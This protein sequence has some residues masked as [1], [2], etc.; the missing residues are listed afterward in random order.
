MSIDFTPNFA[1]HNKL[2]EFDFFSKQTLKLWYNSNVE[3]KGTDLIYTPAL[4]RLIAGSYTGLDRTGLAL[5]SETITNPYALIEYKTDFDLAL[6]HIGPGQW[7]GELHEFSYYRR[8]GKLQRLVISDIMGFEVD[9]RL[10]GYAYY[11][12]ANFL[13]GK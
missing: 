1:S 13:N 12:M 9:A 8:Y 11:L 4:L 6:R 2:V 3:W 10:L 5:T 7:S